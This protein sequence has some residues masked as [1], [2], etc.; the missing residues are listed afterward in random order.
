MLTLRPGQMG[1]SETYA[2]GLVE[3]LSRHGTLEYVC[4]VPPMAAEAGNG[5]RTVLVPEYRDAGTPLRKAAA[6][7]LAAARPGPIRRRFGKVAAMHYPF[8]IPLPQAEAPIAVT[9]QDLLHLE[10]PQ[11]WSRTSRAFRAVAYDRPARRARL[12]IVPSEY[13]RRRA[14]ERLGIPLERIRA[15]HYGIDHERFRPGDEAREPFLLYPAR[16]WRHKNHERLFQ[17][18]ALLRG[19]RPE[20]ELVLT[21]GGHDGRSLPPGVSARGLVSP[22]ELA[23]LYRRAAALV[24]PSLYEGFGYPPLEAMACGCPVAASTATSLPEIC[25]DAAVLFDPRSPEEI[26]AAVARA[27]EDDGELVRRGLERARRFT[28][29]ASAR[30]HEDAYRELVAA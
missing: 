19:Q 17:A 12:V 21:G 3:G 4:F 7:A 16:P 22:D 20:L 11:L 29:G 24:F 10:R 6:M 14:S 23:S 28:W 18:F 2:R 30:R 27:L 15:I 8:T 5:L 25:G 26:A 13:V 1:G 9:L